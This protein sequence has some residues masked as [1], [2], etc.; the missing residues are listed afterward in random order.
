[1][2]SP[3]LWIATS[4]ASTSSTKIIH[5]MSRRRRR[6]IGRQAQLLQRL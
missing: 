3:A 1:M 4:G 2:I 6:R 5:H